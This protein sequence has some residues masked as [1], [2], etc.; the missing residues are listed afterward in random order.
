MGIKKLL[1]KRF[2]VFLIDEFHTSK[3]YNKS[4]TEGENVKINI[5]YEDIDGKIQ[6]GTRK[7]HSV[8]MFESSNGNRE[9]INRDYNATLNMMKIVKSLLFTKK[10]PIKYTRSKKDDQ[11]SNLSGSL[12]KRGEQLSSSEKECIP[13]S[14]KLDLNC[15]QTK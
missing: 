12:I 10:R 1:S 15:K 3:L 7:L 9:C 2:L 8:L 4:E 14:A 13:R 6:M 5:K 11:P